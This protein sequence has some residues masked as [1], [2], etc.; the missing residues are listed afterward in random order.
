MACQHA[1]I[2][3]LKTLGSIPQYHKKIFDLTSSERFKANLIPKMIKKQ[4][5]GMVTCSIKARMNT[6]LDTELKGSGKETR[7]YSKK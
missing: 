2:S 7:R 6:D 1:S 3:M 5:I 4:I